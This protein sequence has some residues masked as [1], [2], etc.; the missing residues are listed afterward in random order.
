MIF[1]QLKKE[2]AKKGLKFDMDEY[3]ELLENQDAFQEEEEN[4]YEGF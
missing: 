2:Y 4:D 1:E 3:L